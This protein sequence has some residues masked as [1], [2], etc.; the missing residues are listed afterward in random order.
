[1]TAYYFTSGHKR[2]VDNM[3]ILE[4]VERQKKKV[5]K[6]NPSQPPLIRGGALK[7]PLIRGDLEGLA[8]YVEAIYFAVRLT[9]F[10]SNRHIAV[11]FASSSVSVIDTSGAT[12]VG[13]T[14]S[15]PGN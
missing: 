15:V 12:L 2:N 3:K 13:M 9:N 7:S 6:P 8:L 4:K 5:A 10:L 14:A 11:Y 1:M